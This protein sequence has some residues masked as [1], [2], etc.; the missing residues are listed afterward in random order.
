MHRDQ[1][2]EA[3]ADGKRY[4]ACRSAARHWIAAMMMDWPC[5]AD[6]PAWHHLR[7]HCVQRRISLKQRNAIHQKN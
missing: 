4:V 5:G 1:T 6:R 7:G 2:Q 3:E